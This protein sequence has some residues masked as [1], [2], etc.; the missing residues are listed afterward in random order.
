MVSDIIPSTIKKHISVMRI[1]LDTGSSTKNF[2]KTPVIT[3]TS[4]MRTVVT[5]IYSPHLSEITIFYEENCFTKNCISKLYNVLKDRV[6]AF[7]LKHMFLQFLNEFF[8]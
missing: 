5:T 2:T 4:M 3:T 8:Q 7:P 1:I 6:P